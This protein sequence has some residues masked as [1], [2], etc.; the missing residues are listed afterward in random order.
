MPHER[1]QYG[2]FGEN[3]AARHL[4]AEGY[5]IVETNYKNRF[6]EIDLIAMDGETIV[7]VEVKSRRSGR[8]GTARASV[9]KAKQ[10][11]ISMVALGYL[12]SNNGIHQK[13]RFDVVTVN[14]CGAH[15]ESNIE[16]IKNAFA[17]AYG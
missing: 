1:Q 5:R 9:S 17:L 12:K 13:A 11:K 15:P 6:G 10:R 14:A 2:Q 3:L 16:V 8:F 7:F 4:A